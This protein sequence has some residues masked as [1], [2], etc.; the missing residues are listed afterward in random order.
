MLKE[1]HLEHRNMEPMFVTY[2]CSDQPAPKI[3]ERKIYGK[4]DNRRAHPS[5][6]FRNQAIGALLIRLV[7]GDESAFIFVVIQSHRHL[8]DMIFH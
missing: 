7:Q 8:T 1:N 4:V 6:S 3:D 5:L 2:A